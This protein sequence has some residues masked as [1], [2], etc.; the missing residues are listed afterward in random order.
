MVQ[1][2]YEVYCPRADCSNQ[3]TKDTFL[4]KYKIEKDEEGKPYVVD[5]QTRGI[6]DPSSVRKIL[7]PLKED[8]TLIERRCPW[9]NQISSFRVPL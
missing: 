4:V 6:G 1:K 9:C 2:T 3:E 8:Y 7:L 5:P